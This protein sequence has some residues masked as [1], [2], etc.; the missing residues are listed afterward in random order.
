MRCRSLLLFSTCLLALVA[1]GGPDSVASPSASLDGEWLLTSGRGPE[2]EVSVPPRAQVTLEVTAG[3]MRGTA[4]CNSYEGR[5]VVDGSK[6]R[7]SRI[8]STEMACDPARMRT[9]H[10]YL[11]ALE[12]VE[13]Y[14]RSSDQLTL[15]GKDTKLTFEFVPVPPPSS[16]TDTEWRLEGLLHGTGMEGTMSSPQAARIRFN[17][18]GTFEGTTGCRD[19]EGR[20]EESG[21]HISTS[22]IELAAGGCRGLK[23]EQDEH[24]VSVFEAGF[25]VSIEE[26]TMALSWDEGE[27]GLYYLVRD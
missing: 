24:L 20:W 8:G 1:C 19:I 18:D 9:E 22:A 5:L 12:T 7:A 21:D 16:F 15:V 25:T 13:T 23:A 11:A 27:R 26:N 4:A 6:I 3:S 10:R 14:R 2:G 17:D